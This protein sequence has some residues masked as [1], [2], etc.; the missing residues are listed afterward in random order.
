[1]D[2]IAISQSLTEEVYERFP[3]ARVSLIKSAGNF[4]YLSRADE[5]VMHIKVFFFLKKFFL[6]KKKINIKLNSKIKSN[7]NQKIQVNK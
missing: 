1:M 2:E 5:V 6:L 7:L 3:N 4:S